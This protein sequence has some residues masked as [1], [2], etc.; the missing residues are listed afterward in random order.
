M[1]DRRRHTG[2]AAPRDLLDAVIAAC[3]EALDER[4]LGSLYR[5]LF[6]TIIGTV[7]YAVAWSLLQACSSLP[8]ETAWPWPSDWIN[9]ESARHR[10]VVWMVGRSAP[11]PVELGGMSFPAGTVLSVSPYLLHHDPRAWADPHA[12]QPERWKHPEQCGPWLPFSA[13]PFTCAGAAIAHTMIN[14]T[15]DALAEGARLTVTGGDTRPLVT[16]RAGPRPFTLHRVR[17]PRPTGEPRAHARSTVK[18]GDHS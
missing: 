6:G 1:R 12:F 18:G 9:R 17:R 5:Q 3:P 8:P 10:P 11:G 14:E 13:G 4:R 2:D 15:L 7:G 16:D